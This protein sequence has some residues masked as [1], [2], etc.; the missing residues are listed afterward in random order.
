MLFQWKESNGFTR[1]SHLEAMPNAVS[2]EK[3]GQRG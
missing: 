2:V 1:V 3:A